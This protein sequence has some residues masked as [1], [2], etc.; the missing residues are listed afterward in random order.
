MILIGAVRHEAM[1]K[2]QHR[3]ELGAV[4]GIGGGWQSKLGQRTELGA[5]TWKRTAT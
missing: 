3:I 4:Q 1:T 2:I 5:D